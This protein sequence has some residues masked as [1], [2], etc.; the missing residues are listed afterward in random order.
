MKQ[1]REDIASLPEVNRKKYSIVAI[2]YFSKW[3]EIKAVENKT[4]ETVARFLFE[5]ICRHPCMSIQI[6][7]QGRD[8]LIK[9]QPVFMS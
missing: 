3:S 9:F 2:N 6:N 8:S 7:D 4:A 5:L 1:I